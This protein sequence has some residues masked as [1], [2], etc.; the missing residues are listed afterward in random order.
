MFAKPGGETSSVMNYIITPMATSAVFKKLEEEQEAYDAERRS[1]SSQVPEEPA[2]GT[3]PSKGN[4]GGGKGRGRGRL[5]KAKAK[6]KSG[7]GNQAQV[8]NPDCDDAHDHDKPEVHSWSPMA[9]PMGSNG[10]SE[11]GRHKTALDDFMHIFIRISES[12]KKTISSAHSK[13]IQMYDSSLLTLF[14]HAISCFFEFSWTGSVAINGKFV[15][16]Y[17]NFR[18]E[19]IT[20]VNTACELSASAPSSGAK[21]GL[22]LA[23]HIQDVLDS[24]TGFSFGYQVK[25]DSDES[26][27]TLRIQSAVEVMKQNGMDAFVNDVMSLPLEFHAK[28][29]VVSQ[30]AIYSATLSHYF[31]RYSLLNSFEHFELCGLLG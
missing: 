15:R 20:F 23:T 21:K 30:L 5:S 16:S 29:T 31:S 7:V 6:A 24:E 18:Q 3:E 2:V 28:F 13:N 26:R 22:T 10:L 14:G 4:R 17:T 11:S 27:A 1:A 19:I 25:D 9:Y 12:W 8:G